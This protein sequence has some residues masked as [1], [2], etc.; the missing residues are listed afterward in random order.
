MTSSE[1]IEEFLEL[2]IAPGNRGAARSALRK[3][4]ALAEARA[5]TDQV[6]DDLARLR[7]GRP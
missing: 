5:R 6:K 1:M 2:F 7:A 3:M 4:I